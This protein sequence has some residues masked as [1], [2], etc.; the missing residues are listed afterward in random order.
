VSP[1]T[2]EF[3]MIRDFGVGSPSTVRI[4][5]VDDSTTGSLVTQ[6][7]GN[8]QLTNSEWG[9]GLVHVRLQMPQSSKFENRPVHLEYVSN[10]IAPGLGTGWLLDNI[11]VSDV[12]ALPDDS[13]P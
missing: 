5:M 10:A 6:E 2:V 3:D 12:G 8:Y 1:F 13:R 4:L 9:T 7:I 11:V